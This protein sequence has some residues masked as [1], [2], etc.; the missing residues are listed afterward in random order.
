MFRLFCTVIFLLGATVFPK[1]L[2]G[3]TQS[4]S[5][6]A[7]AAAQCEFQTPN[8]VPDS[9]I[10]V[11]IIGTPSQDCF[12]YVP[13]EF[14]ASYFGEGGNIYAEN[15]NLNA[16]FLNG[17]PAGIRACTPRD[18][19]DWFTNFQKTSGS[20][21]NIKIDWYKEETID[22][23]GQNI[24]LVR[25]IYSCQ[26]GNIAQVGSISAMI[27]AAAPKSC[28]TAAG[29]YFLPR[30]SIS[31]RTCDLSQITQSE[32]CVPHGAKICHKPTCSTQ[33]HQRGY[34]NGGYCSPTEDCTCNSNLSSN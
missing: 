14:K 16:I 10:P 7:A 3:D 32:K 23:G 9:W 19:A 13:Q 29:G 6:L 11:V 17:N 12:A 4:A 33:C 21:S 26:R 8:T 15:S 28:V 20:C 18:Y 27:S 30:T 2:W 5:E 24:P 22:A 34:T 25:I 31:T 1:T